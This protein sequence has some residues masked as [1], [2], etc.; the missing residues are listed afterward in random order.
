MAGGYPG[1]F[2]LSATPGA[3]M[4]VHTFAA[5]GTYYLE[6]WSTNEMRGDLELLV[7][8]GGR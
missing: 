6:V 4:I 5:A 1:G 3:A 2:E 7:R 8:R